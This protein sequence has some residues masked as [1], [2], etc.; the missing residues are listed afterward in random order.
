[1]AE[2]E[3]SKLNNKTSNTTTYLIYTMAICKGSATTNMVQSIHWVPFPN[4]VSAV[5]D[6]IDV[7]RRKCPGG[8]CRIY[9]VCN[10]L[11]TTFEVRKSV[12]DVIRYVMIFW[13]V[14]CAIESQ[15][16]AHSWPFIFTYILLHVTEWSGVHMA[17]RKCLLF[18][19][20]RFSEFRLFML[21]TF[22]LKV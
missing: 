13:I 3:I 14:V 21:V 18:R 5:L 9:P 16:S 12:C 1:M 20:Q 15:D 11:N 8:R 17:S 2:H 22:L 10:Y 7:F 4:K 19:V 6:E